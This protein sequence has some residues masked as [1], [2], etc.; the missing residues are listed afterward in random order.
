MYRF[1]AIIFFASPLALPA[2]MAGFWE[3]IVDLG[4]LEIEVNCEF[5]E[6]AGK[7]NGRCWSASGA[8]RHDAAATGSVEGERVNV[9]YSFPSDRSRITFRFVG[10]S[11]PDSS[12]NG[13]FILTPGD[14]T[15][16]SKGIFTAAKAR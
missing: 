15:A 7:L 12:L 9:T 2:A 6:N 13:D 1:L 16:P 11:E 4:G 5:A 14:G 10:Q 8:L 3:F